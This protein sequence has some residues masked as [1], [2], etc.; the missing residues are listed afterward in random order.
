MGLT[1]DKNLLASNGQDLQIM[2]PGFGKPSAFY[3]KALFE[4]KISKFAIQTSLW[5]SPRMI[6]VK[7]QPLE[8]KELDSIINKELNTKL[9][10]KER[11]SIADFHKRAFDKEAPSNMYVTRKDA[12]SPNEHP[13]WFFSQK[14]G[15]WLLEA[16][17]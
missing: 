4:H 16:G 13:N 10:A 2:L 3:Q 7:K 17:Q 15:M 9:T 5:L 6:K 8:F 14:Q 1:F 12:F 11:K